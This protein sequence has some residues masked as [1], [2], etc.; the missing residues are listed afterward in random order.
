[1]SPDAD[2]QRDEAIAGPII[3]PDI[4]PDALEVPAGVVVRCSSISADDCEVR[5]LLEGGRALWARNA[6]LAK[7]TRSNPEEVA[8]GC[9]YA[10]LHD[11][12]SASA[13]FAR[14]TAA[15]TAQERALAQRN[16]DRANQHG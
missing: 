13:A 15:G 8:L 9:A 11:W 5:D 2:P 16:L 10:H 12:P 14:A 3:G 6:L 4:T 1:M 7:A